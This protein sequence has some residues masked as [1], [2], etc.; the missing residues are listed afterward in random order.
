MQPHAHWSG[1]ADRLRAGSCCIMTS[2]AAMLLLLWR[3]G[4][5]FSLPTLPLPPPPRQ[6][7]FAEAPGGEGN[8]Q[9]HPPQPKE[10]VVA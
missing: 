1:R 9:Q 3:V 2:R 5:T 10:V 4:H 6:E 8:E 7:D